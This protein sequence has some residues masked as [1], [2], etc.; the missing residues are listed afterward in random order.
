MPMRSSSGIEEQDN[1]DGELDCP[2]HV[3]L[4]ATML[5]C[6]P[7]FLSIMLRPGLV[8]EHLKFHD[9]NCCRQTQA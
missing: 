7:E 9:G 5:G 3:R 2:V 8:A 1:G 6:V 4:Q